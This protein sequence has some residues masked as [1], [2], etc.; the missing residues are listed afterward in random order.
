MVFC[1][2]SD[3]ID[4]SRMQSQGSIQ[5]QKGTM[6]DSTYGQNRTG[7]SY[8][9]R[10]YQERSYS[11]SDNGSTETV[12]RNGKPVTQTAWSDGTTLRNILNETSTTGTKIRHKPTFS[13]E[14]LVELKG[15]ANAVSEIT[16]PPTS[17]SRRILSHSFISEL[18]NRSTSSQGT[19][20]NGCTYSGTW[21]PTTLPVYNLKETISKV[22][23]R[24]KSVLISKKRQKQKLRRKS[25]FREE[26]DEPLPSS[27]AFYDGTDDSVSEQPSPGPRSQTRR[28]TRAFYHEDDEL[29]QP[30]PSVSHKDYPQVDFGPWNTAF[31]LYNEAKRSPTPQAADYSGWGAVRRNTL[32]P[33]AKSTT[34]RPKFELGRSSTTLS[35]NSEDHERIQTPTGKPPAGQ[36]LEIPGIRKPCQSDKSNRS[37]NSLR[38]YINRLRSTPETAENDEEVVSGQTQLP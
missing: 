4:N 7:Y 34:S 21:I 17:P 38:S 29:E 31:N 19:K 14:D 9:H 33:L 15:V 26:F 2:S 24:H 28:Q 16:I 35:S 27:Q 20:A 11:S 5:S 32:H 22:P 30:V 1:S 18:S 6:G 12:L 37:Q 36:F 3:L 23:G 10:P 8:D 13:F 25:R